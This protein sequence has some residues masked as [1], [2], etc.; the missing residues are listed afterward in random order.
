MTFFQ[1][2]RTAHIHKYFVDSETGD[3]LCL[4]GK[5]KDAKEASKWHNIKTE[6]DGKIYHSAFEANYAAELDWRKKAGE[7]V[8]WEMQVKLDLRS[9]GFHIANYYIDFIAHYPDGTIEYIECKGGETTEWRMKWR[10]L[11]AMMDEEVKS[12]AVR[13]LLVK[14]K[15]SKN[16]ITKRKNGFQR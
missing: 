16:K 6:Y 5:P 14:L 3:Q 13:L 7:I 15:P 11:E 4:C 1:Q 9:N 8:F 12:G 2:G 10:L